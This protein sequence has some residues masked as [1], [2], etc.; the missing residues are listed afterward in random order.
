MNRRLKAILLLV[1]FT[2]QPAWA[3]NI[4]TSASGSGERIQVLRGMAETLIKESQQR[5]QLSEGEE[6]IIRSGGKTEIDTNSEAKK[7]TESLSKLGNSIT[8][9]EIPEL[10]AA[11][12]SSIS[13]GFRQVQDDF[14]TLSESASVST[15]EKTEFLKEGERLAGKA[16]ED[17]VILQALG[18]KIDTALASGSL[19]PDQRNQL[20]S[21]QRLLAD[22]RMAEQGTQGEIG[23]MLK[24]DFKTEA[25]SGSPDVD[26]L[27]AELRV[28]RE[29]LDAIVREMQ[30]NPN[31][32]SQD[33]FRDAQ[34]KIN[35]DLK[36]LGELTTQLQ[37]LLEKDPGNEQ[38]KAL[39]RQLSSIGT[40]MVQTLKSLTVVQIDTGT[41]TD[42]RMAKDELA[43]AMSMLQREIDS[44]NSVSG[45]KTL[46]E[47]LRSDLSTLSDNEYRRFKSLLWNYEQASALFQE[48]QRQY[49]QMM[50]ASAGQRYLTSE[51]EEI[52]AMFQSMLDSFQQLGTLGGDLQ[53]SLTRWQELGGLY[54]DSRIPPQPAIATQPTQFQLIN[55]VVIQTTSTLGNY[56]YL[57]WGQWNDGNGGV[58]TSL[59]NP[60]WIAGSLTPAVNIPLGG[61]ATYNG[62]VLGK[63]DESGTISRVAGTTSLTADFGQRALNGSF[64]N[65]TK[66]GAAWTSAS[67]NASWAAGTNQI[68]GTVNAPAVSMSGTVNG[69]FFGPT[70]NQVGGT[71]TL[72]GGAN[73]A[74]GIFVGNRP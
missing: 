2:A 39:S 18:Q 14:K 23:K 65:L 17:Q 70:A 50:R 35:E 46:E 42:F 1:L 44:F 4:S 34:D 47:F 67:V 30:S 40:Q 24:T 10:L 6:L 19:T 25:L 55:D 16:A 28:R 60:Y 43:R 9:A 33:W 5:I 26:A 73:K 15:E 31:G 8:L 57:S 48:Y 63:L 41:L 3:T 29:S 51:Q 12:K 56:D 20:L 22:T 53:A 52:R 59:D 7:W 62:Q 58:N 69:N 66:N 71:W 27:A 13:E 61:T 36:S 54:T 37:D 38:L 68:S 32:H 64:D 72:N 45:G 74:A 21:Y 11:M 49:E